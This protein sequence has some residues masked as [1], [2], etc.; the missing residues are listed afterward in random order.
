MPMIEIKPEHL[1]Y[2]NR[3]LRSLAGLSQVDVL[4]ALTIALDYLCAQSPNKTESVGV[5]MSLLA[6]S[7]GHNTDH[8]IVRAVLDALIEI[9]RAEGVAST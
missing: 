5:A 9:R 3:A 2:A 8:P 6:Q 1:E 4:L 7:P